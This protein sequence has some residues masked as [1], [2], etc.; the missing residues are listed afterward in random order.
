MSE[1]IPKPQQKKED[2]QDGE[3]KNCKVTSKL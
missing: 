2:N 1:K 3:E